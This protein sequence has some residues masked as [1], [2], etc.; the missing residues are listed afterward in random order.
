MTYTCTRQFVDHNGKKHIV[1]NT[2]SERD[3]LSLG[4]FEREH[5]IK[6]KERKREV[7]DGE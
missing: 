7:G 2:I 1:G 6:K 4:F 5:Y 3:Y